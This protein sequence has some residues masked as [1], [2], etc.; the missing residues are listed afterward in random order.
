[1]DDSGVIINKIIRSDRKTLSL[2]INKNGELVVRAPK[3]VSNNY[4]MNFVKSKT[5]WIKDKQKIF[6]HQKPELKFENLNSIMVLGKEYKL[7]YKD[8]GK[9]L[10]RLEDERIIININKK[11]RADE[12]FTLW[13][14]KNAKVLLIGRTKYLAQKNNF[15]ISTVR[16]SNAK[17]RWGSCSSKK[18]INL[19]WRLMM[20]PPSVADYVIIHE[21][22]H[23]REMN[24]SK[25]FWKVVRDIL[26][27][28]KEQKNWLK[29]NG[30]LL[31]I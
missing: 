15:K 16:I 22:A 27:D 21:L 24:H 30:N 6:K 17:G 31:D 8:I 20:A 11:D 19:S 29:L 2:E 12:I 10:I 28:Y 26:P 4:I 9:E 3:K 13:L 23:T 18:S 5:D 1:M 14:K 25:S 7:F